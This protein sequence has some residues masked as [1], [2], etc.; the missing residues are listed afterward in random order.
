MSESEVFE[1]VGERRRRRRRRKSGGGVEGSG[2]MGGS[3]EA[4]E[5]IG[6]AA[7]QPLGK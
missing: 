1:A 4:N 7:V 6:S 3:R 2:E 5:S